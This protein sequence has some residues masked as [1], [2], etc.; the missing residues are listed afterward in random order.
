M[1]KVEIKEP[2]QKRYYKGDATD[3]KKCRRQDQC[4]F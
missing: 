1:A 2:D 4:R 3:A